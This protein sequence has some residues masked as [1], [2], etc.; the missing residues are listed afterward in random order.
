MSRRLQEC[1]P[2]WTKDAQMQPDI[3]SLCV[4]PKRLAALASYAILD[5]LP[6]PAFDD[7][8]RLAAAVCQVPVATVTFVDEVR[9]W[10]KAQHGM[11]ATETPLHS[12]ICAHTMAGEDVL[13]VP[14]TALDPRFAEMP[15]IKGKPGFRFYAGAP[16]R[17][18]QGDSL[19]SVA[20]L[21][22]QP[23]YF[24][25]AQIELLRTLARQVMTHLELRK[26]MAEQK[27]TE[28]ELREYSERLSVA[29]SA[30]DLGDWD[31]DPVTDLM[32][33][34]QRG[35]EIYG[36]SPDQGVL[37]RSEMR[38]LIDEDF[39]QLALDR[40]ERADQKN[41]EYDIEYRV[42]HPDGRF[43]WVAAHGRGL[44]DTEGKLIRT[45]GVVQDITLRK[46]A[47]AALRA[48]EI[49]SRL[50]A[51]LSERTRDIEDPQALL[52]TMLELVGRH[53]ATD[54][55]A[56]AEYAEDGVN[57]VV[58]TSYEASGE[59]RLPGNYKLSDFGTRIL[60]EQQ[61]GQTTVLRN[62]AS[63]LEREAGDALIAN[64]VSSL[65]CCPLLRNGTL[66]ATMAVHHS[67]PR[68]WTSDE[69]SL[70]QAVSERC[71]AY[72]ERARSERAARDGERRFRLVADS[73]PQ[74]AWMAR[75]DGSIFWFNRRWYDFTGLTFAES[76]GWG[77]QK[78]HH[79]DESDHVLER[80]RKELTG[81]NQAWEDTFRLLGQDGSY[82]W[83][84]SRAL[85]LKD[86]DGKILLWFGTHTDVT[87]Q[88]NANKEREQLLASEREARSQAERASYLKDEFL[89]TLS[90]ELRTPLNAILGWS[91]ILQDGDAT[92]EDLAQGLQTIERNARS[93]TR[94]IEDLLDMSR[95]ISG[96]IRLD[97]TTVDLNALAEA[98]LETVKP[99]AAA[100]GIKL[101]LDL[102][103]ETCSVSG[104]SSRLQQVLWNLLSNAIKFTTSGGSVRLALSRLGEEFEVSVSDTGQG[105]GA[106]FLPHVFDRF[107]QADSSMTRKFG[108]LGLGLSIVKQLTELHGGR[109]R[110]ESPGKG[111]GA[112]FT[113]SLPESYV[114]APSGEDVLVVPAVEPASRGSL[115][116]DLRGVKVLIVDDEPDARVLLKRLLSECGAIVSEAEDAERAFQL[117]QEELPHV[118]VSDIGLPGENGYSLLRRVRNL[119][120]SSGGQTPAIALTA[121]ARAEDREAALEAGFQQHLTKPFDA[122]ELLAQ[123]ASAV[124]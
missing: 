111:E 86:E 5:T 115:D 68:N 104:D 67:S 1:T 14:D 47:E 24:S 79:P 25:E 34:S 10:F 106:D 97:V 103:W 88:L 116:V 36:L 18:A 56:Y 72:V 59:K 80:Y 20:V 49:R 76:Q 95:I 28:R 82:H 63:E 54:S 81:G 50:L 118:L 53:F 69:I 44:Y 109:V 102:P 60:M 120:A 21:D 124:K 65:I 74:M 61:S 77:W 123:V 90:H 70:M 9:Q 73:I 112:T 122:A 40:A 3:S 19:G 89:A 119:E 84:L 37:T 105:I 27:K 45:L 23:R 99:A 31:W 101:T 121:Y 114:S 71:W 26:T 22:Y 113:V 51:E 117:L 57:F 92:P 55:C 15:N 42:R 87:D 16:L 41:G 94:I 96:K 11:G 43:V 7:I 17:S 98:A 64:G 13:I 83:H 91:E 48:S 29:M 12:A 30:A 32:K 58:P 52:D 108:G 4:D 39:R 75:P 110:V 8:T 62:V 2:V 66:R 33:L 85:P 38:N 107:R 35:R 93:Q 6:E 46:E 78:L 100:R